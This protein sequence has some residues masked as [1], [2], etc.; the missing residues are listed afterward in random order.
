MNQ[1]KGRDYIQI[2]KP[3]KEFCVI[4]IQ[5]KKHKQ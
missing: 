5:R 4:I 1:N 3:R 2:K